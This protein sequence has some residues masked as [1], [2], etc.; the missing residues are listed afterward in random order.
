MQAGPPRLGAGK[1]RRARGARHGERGFPGIRRRRA[2]AAWPWLR[3]GNRTTV[4][5]KRA[6]FPA[7]RARRLHEVERVRGP[8]AETNRPEFE[9]SFELLDN[10][11]PPEDRVLEAGTL[12]KV[13]HGRSAGER[14]RDM[15][16]RRLEAQ[17]PI[18]VRIFARAAQA[19]LRGLA[20]IAKVVCSVL[21]SRRSTRQ[22]ASTPKPLTYLYRA[23][24]NA[25]RR[26]PPK[27]VAWLARAEAIEPDGSTASGAAPPART[28]DPWEEAHRR[29]RSFLV[30]R[31]L[32]RVAQPKRAM[33]ILK[34][35]GFTSRE[36][37]RTLGR[38]RAA[39]RYHVSTGL[40]GLR[41]E[42]SADDRRL[43][44]TDFSPTDSNT[45]S[46]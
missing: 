28:L 7:G 8:G 14:L 31:L 17:Y 40:K 18:L 10:P 37:E 20:A 26:R 23:V 12:E 4:P 43:V 6:T 38:S 39:V 19:E 45:M 21:S 3:G 27:K 22:L 2:T 9:Q 15:A 5:A 46:A 32:A 34:M 16:A 33:I 25:L 35:R 13:S 36:I 1:S 24:Q 41:R 11:R 29:E 30:E 44:L 42:L